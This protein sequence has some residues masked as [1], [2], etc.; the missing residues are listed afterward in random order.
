MA[1][2]KDLYGNDVMPSFGLT[3]GYTK[4]M[5]EAGAQGIQNDVVDVHEK[6]QA[7]HKLA[8]IFKSKSPL[9]ISMG[10]GD[11]IEVFSRMAWT[12]LEHGR[13]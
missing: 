5:I 7:K 2:S 11:M 10:T 6:L 4:P 3:K 8:L 9:E 13:C 1:I 12:K